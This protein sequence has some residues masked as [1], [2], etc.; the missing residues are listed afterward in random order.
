MPGGVQKTVSFENYM[1]FIGIAESLVFYVQAFIFFSNKNFDLSSLIL[2][3][4]SA[5]AFV[6]WLIYGIK[7]KDRVLI[8]TN[9]VALVGVLI[10]A[11]SSKISE[12]S[13]FMEK[14]FSFFV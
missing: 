10:A 5:L 3:L 4:V 14:I 9:S 8:Y 7:I 2:F 11:I 1:L 13:S 6:S 12:L